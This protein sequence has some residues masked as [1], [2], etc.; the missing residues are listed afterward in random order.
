MPPQSPIDIF[1]V[2]GSF[3]QPDQGLGQ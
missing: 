1:H 2:S 3:S